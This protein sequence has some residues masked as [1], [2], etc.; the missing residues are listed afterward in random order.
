[1]VEQQNSD[2][3][4]MEID[5]TLTLE[6]K[7]IL[8]GQILK[9]ALAYDTLLSRDKSSEEAIADLKEHPNKYDPALVQALIAGKGGASFEVMTLPITKLKPGMILDQNIHSVSGTLLVAKGQEL[10]TAVLLRLISS[11]ENEIISGPVRV[12]LVTNT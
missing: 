10:S 2:V 5:S 11:E 12:L 4:K 7:G 3:D 6:Q 8:G 9:V 1:M